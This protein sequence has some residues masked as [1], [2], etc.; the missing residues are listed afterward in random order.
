MARRCRLAFGR[1]V[2]PAAL[3]SLAI[4]VLP[5]A[6]AGPNSFY[7]GQPTVAKSLENLAKYSLFHHPLA[8]SL[9]RVLPEAGFWYPLLML[10]VPLVLAATA[11][12]CLVAASRWRSR[13]SCRQIEGTDQFLLLGGGSLILSVALLALVHFLVNFQ[14]NHYGEWRFDRSTKQMVQLIRERQRSEPRPTVRVGVR[15]LFEQSLSF[16][17][18]RYRLAWMQPVAWEGPDGSFDYYILSLDDSSLVAKRGL[19]VLYTDAFAN[20]VLAAAPGK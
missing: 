2:A 4:L 5:L 20:V 15:W 1:F 6:K 13:V 3:T 18:E 8:G 10:F 14:T 19:T 16:Y 12:A 7:V 11:L 17:R 9:A